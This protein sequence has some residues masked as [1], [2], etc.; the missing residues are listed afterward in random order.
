[1]ALALGFTKFTR[2]LVNTFTNGFSVALVISRFN[3]FVI[4]FRAHGDGVTAFACFETA[5]AYCVAL[6]FF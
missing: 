6:T 4:A 1:M 2:A 3:F 5:N